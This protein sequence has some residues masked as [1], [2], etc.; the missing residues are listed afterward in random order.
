VDSTYARRA[1]TLVATFALAG[2]VGCFRTALD[3]RVPFSGTAAGQDARS[4]G[5]VDV[6]PAVGD[7]AQQPTSDA[8]DLAP[9][10]GDTSRDLSMSC[11][12]DL[13]GN[14]T[15]ATAY[16]LNLP[17]SG[18]LLKLP[19]LWACPGAEDWFV[20]DLPASNEM[21]FEA[22][23]DLGT[24][25]PDTYFDVSFFREEYQDPSPYAGG[26][27]QGGGKNCKGTSLWSA[28]GRYYFKVTS[29]R[30][31]R[32]EVE[33]YGGAVSQSCREDAYEPNDTAATATPM[34]MSQSYS[35]DACPT[36][37]D[38]FSMNVTKGQKLNLKIDGWFNGYELEMALFTPSDL[39]NPLATYHYSPDGAK[40]VSYLIQESGVLLLR[41]R[42]TKGI[43]RTYTLTVTQ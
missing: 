7:Q 16:A 10:L 15:Q 21:Q 36:D 31:Q 14:S 17:T 11:V 33:L 18:I 40:P 4:A 19:D 42:N 25:F 39:V 30:P 38:W 41:L 37:L 27:S 6:R 1:S 23:Y 28:P 3:E 9:A 34:K 24:S 20:L 26:G 2:A 32:Y 13:L 29:G 8:Q 35:G 12:D 22:C 43:D 5:V